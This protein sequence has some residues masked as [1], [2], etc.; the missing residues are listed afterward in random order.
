MLLTPPPMTTIDGL[1]MCKQRGEVQAQRAESALE[2]VNR[3]RIA[4]VGR[5]LDDFDIDGVEMALN[6]NR[7]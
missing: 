3:Q 1:K 5:L 2:Y 7:T 6:V 4:G